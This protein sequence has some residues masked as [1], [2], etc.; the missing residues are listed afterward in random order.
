M[1]KDSVNKSLFL[2]LKQLKNIQTTFQR[3]AVFYLNTKKLYVYERVRCGRLN[4]N[5]APETSNIVK[6]M[7][8]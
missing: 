3:E 7:V 1:S 6:I 8:K 5:L 2:E 4:K